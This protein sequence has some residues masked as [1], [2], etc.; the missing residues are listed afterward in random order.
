MLGVLVWGFGSLVGVGKSGVGSRIVLV[1]MR[2]GL[3]QGWLIHK[4]SSQWIGS[5]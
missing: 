3:V 4:V 5:I 2:G 1:S